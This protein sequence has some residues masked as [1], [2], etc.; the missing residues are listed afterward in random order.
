MPRPT[1]TNSSINKVLVDSVTHEIIPH[2]L[3][4]GTNVVDLPSGVQDGDKVIVA[5][6]SIAIPAA[7]TTTGEY[8]LYFS[9]SD[10]TITPL[11]TYVDN[12]VHYFD[13]GTTS[14][15]GELVF[16]ENNGHLSVV[17]ADTTSTT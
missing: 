14:Q 16:Y 10:G 8:R 11:W 1:G 7:P 6:N 9:M 17:Y 5:S 3:T 2:R 12:T 4:D 13:E 15:L